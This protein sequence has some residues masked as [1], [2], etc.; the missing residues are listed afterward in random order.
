MFINNN[1]PFAPFFQAHLERA[2]LSNGTF[3][4]RFEESEESFINFLKDS[5]EV[6]L[7]KKSHTYLVRLEGVLRWKTSKEQVSQDVWKFRLIGAIVKHIK[8]DKEKTCAL[9]LLKTAKQWTLGESIAWALNNWSD[10]P[11]EK[12]YT[13]EEVLVNKSLYEQKVIKASDYLK[14]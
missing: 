1:K 14:A 2:Y 3:G 9:K 8:T 4:F 12:K 10:K 5:C 7:P 6:Q 13:E 11:V